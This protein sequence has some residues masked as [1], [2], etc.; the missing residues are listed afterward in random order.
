MR[1]ITIV[2]RL[3][4]Q[5]GPFLGFCIVRCFLPDHALDGVECPPLNHGRVTV[6]PGVAGVLQQT[7]HLVFVPERGLRAER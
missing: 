6:L 7:L 5:G 3:E 4:P 2:I 1:G